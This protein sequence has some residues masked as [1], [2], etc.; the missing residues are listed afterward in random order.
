M[1]TLEYFLIAESCSVDAERNSLSIFHVMNDVRVDQFPAFIP[2]LV[3]VSAWVHNPEELE[4]RTESQ[5]RIE[6]RMP[7]QPPVSFRGNLTAEARFQNVNLTFR[8]VPIPAAGDTI[9]DVLLNEV[10]QAT[11]TIAVSARA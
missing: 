3:V 6:F 1:P 8:E 5:I 4:R 10:H 7:G 11:H 9:V 2:E